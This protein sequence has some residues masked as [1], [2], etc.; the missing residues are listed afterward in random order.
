MYIHIMSA[1]L[2]S[3]TCL[4]YVSCFTN[5]EKL[6]MTWVCQVKIQDAIELK[7]RETKMCAYYWI[8]IKVRFI[9]FT[10]TRLNRIFSIVYDVIKSQ[11]RWLEIQWKL[12]G[13]SLRTVLSHLTKEPR[14]QT[15]IMW[16]DLYYI[17]DNIVSVEKNWSSDSL[18]SVN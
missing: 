3:F 15:F 17:F 14:R 1:R 6:N 4:K 5:K 11:G 7:C 16:L 10:D 12:W 9:G 18:L 2:V 8:W 13:S